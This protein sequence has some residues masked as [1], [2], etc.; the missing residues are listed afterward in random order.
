MKEI[1]IIYTVKSMTKVF[2][3]DLTNKS[4]AEIAQAIHDTFVNEY[5]YDLNDT[6][7]LTINAMALNKSA[8]EM[9]QMIQS[10][11]ISFE[12]AE[13]SSQVTTHDIPEPV[14]EVADFESSFADA[15]DAE[16]KEVDTSLSEKLSEVQSETVD[17]NSDDTDSG[18]ET[19]LSSTLSAKS[20]HDSKYMTTDFSE[21]IPDDVLINRIGINKISPA[22]EFK[23][24]RDLLIENP[25]LFTNVILVVRGKSSLTARR[26]QSVADKNNL[27]VAQLDN[28][29]QHYVEMDD[30]KLTIFEFKLGESSED[31]EI[32]DETK[33]EQKDT[34]YHDQAI[35]AANDLFDQ[36]AQ[37]NQEII[38]TVEK[39]EVVDPFTQAAK[40]TTEVVEQVDPFAQAA[41]E[42]T[43]TV[44]QVDPFTSQPVVEETNDS[45]V[46]V[47]QTETV[48]P[49]NPVD[50][51][52]IDNF[53]FEDVVTDPV[54]A[55]ETVPNV[56]DLDQMFSS[57]FDMLD[58]NTIK[59][60]E[61]RT[62]IETLKQHLAAGRQLN[63]HLQ[64]QLTEANKILENGSIQ[65]NNVV[66]QLNTANQ[67]ITENNSEIE[68]LKNNVS[69]LTVQST[70]LS[71]QL[72]EKTSQLDA[73]ALAIPDNIKQKLDYEK[74][75][76]QSSD[77]KTLYVLQLS[78][79]ARNN[80][81]GL[82]PEIVALAQ[83]LRTN[84]DLFNDAVQ[85]LLR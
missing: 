2:Q 57:P 60:R 39:I 49:F 25:T 35:Q 84:V 70:Q 18:D 83:E 62:E 77:Q 42:T 47:E 24:I 80:T 43:E 78:D 68:S 33:A 52:S 16:F 73:L 51:P 11:E 10:G 64:G 81:A 15:I 40:E 22:I 72:Q 36:N 45:S 5:G 27:D 74:Q 50:V 65:Y 44:E 12:D 26:K 55:S 19:D 41:Q 21:D 48:Q 17:T 67:T 3:C 13:E 37:A 58:G 28:Y 75:K 9:L 66:Q 8:S 69:Q 34:S 7:I 76:L 71:T 59:I 85:Y 30:T 32:V 20:Q 56:S 53:A 63:E 54:A 1:Q 61:L 4:N 38:G 14:V 6:I 23:F 79:A 46:E 29:V 82:T 31:V